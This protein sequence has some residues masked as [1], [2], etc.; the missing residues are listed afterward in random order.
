MSIPAKNHPKWVEV[1]TGKKTFDLKFLAVKIMLGRVIR[2]LS[3]DPSPA[4]IQGA[5]D[6]LHSIYE[7][8]ESNPAVKEDLKTI[9]G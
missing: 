1:V 3:A 6:H 7:K 2:S 5:I 4:N 9:F 8:N